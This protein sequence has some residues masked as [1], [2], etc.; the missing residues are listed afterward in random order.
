MLIRLL[1]GSGPRGLAAM[2]AQAPGLFGGQATLIRPLLLA[3]RQDVQSHLQRHEITV[4][5]DPSNANPKYLRSRVRHE[6]LPLL[7]ELSPGIIGHLCGLATMQATTLGEQVDPL[8][9]LGRA[10]RLE[11]QQL[12]KRHCDVF[13]LQLLFSGMHAVP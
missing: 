2:P 3:R 13:L 5:E 8:A 4:A 7:T 10:Q 12:L 11:V 9:S 1:R 6:L